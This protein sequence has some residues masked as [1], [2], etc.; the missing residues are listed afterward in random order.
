MILC[1]F[2][3]TYST[4]AVIHFVLNSIFRNRD[5][6]TSSVLIINK[7]S[8]FTNMN[9]NLLLQNLVLI[10]DKDYLYHKMI[11]ISFIN[12]L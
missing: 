6:V 3:F 10:A 12:D 4:C 7:M 9:F 1:S 8:F 11:S 2:L 5:Y